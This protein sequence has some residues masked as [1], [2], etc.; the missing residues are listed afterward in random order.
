MGAAVPLQHYTSVEYIVKE[1]TVRFGTYGR[2]LW[3]FK[4]ESALSSGLFSFTATVSNQDA[5]LQWSITSEQNLISCEIERSADAMHFNSIGSVKPSGSAAGTHR[6]NYTDVKIT[7]YNSSVLYYR[8][9]M[10]GKNGAVTYSSVI[11]V[12]LY[13]ND[14]IVTAWPNPAKDYLYTNL[15]LS[16]SADITVSLISAGGYVVYNKQYSCTIGNTNFVIPLQQLKT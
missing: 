4:I 5:K 16:G 7:K 12:R 2:G 9:K 6:Y 3:D 8:I 1:N 10:T 13:G 15:H 11:P 14:V